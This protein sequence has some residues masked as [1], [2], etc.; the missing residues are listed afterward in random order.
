MTDTPKPKKKSK[1]TL[2]QQY[3]ATRKG[4]QLA[5]MQVRQARK[6]LR[7]LIDANDEKGLR[8]MLMDTMHEAKLDGCDRE[9]LIEIAFFILKEFDMIQAI[10]S[11][12]ET[13]ATGTIEGKSK[14]KQK[15]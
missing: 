2:K 12:R 10:L 3:I 11:I 5:L 14:T 9:T 8:L 13:T 7:S 6:G 4:T 15:R 1:L